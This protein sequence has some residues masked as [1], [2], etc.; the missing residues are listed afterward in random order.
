[1]TKACVT[2]GVEK[3]LTFFRVTKKKRPRKTSRQ[4]LN[5]PRVCVDGRKRECRACN[6]TRS[7]RKKGAL[8]QA[9]VSARAVERQSRLERERLEKPPR[10]T[11]TSPDELRRLLR[12]LLVERCAAEGIC[13]QTATYRARY[14]LDPAFRQ[15][16]IERT[17]ARKA[18]SGVMRTDARSTL[19]VHS[20]G[21]L[22]PE[23][24]RRLFAD[25][26]SC[27]Y[28]AVRLTARIKTLDHIIPTSRGG[29]H[30]RENVVVCCSSC[31]T[32]KHA[33]T[34]LE[35]LIADPS[36]VAGAA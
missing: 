33:R 3:A 29:E 7:R 20:D 16:E 10:V 8:S 24:M 5:D 25:A 15:R 19:D 18:R 2:C 34:P 36:A 32:R 11:P 21:S 12:R 31:N 23:V 26:V 17:W 14:K 28:C 30:S 13:L 4:T 35:W 9:M 22:T 1:M 6:K 27:P